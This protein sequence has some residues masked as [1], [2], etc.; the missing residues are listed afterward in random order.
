[1]FKIDTVVSKNFSIDLSMYI[2]MYYIF[3]LLCVNIYTSTV[4]AGNDLSSNATSTDN[5][6]INATRIFKPCIDKTGKF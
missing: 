5:I 3:P 6:G 1:M 2:V 4:V